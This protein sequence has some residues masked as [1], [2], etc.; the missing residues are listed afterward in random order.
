MAVQVQGSKFLETLAIEGR[1]ERLRID[2][3]MGVDVHPGDLEGSRV[4]GGLPELERVADHGVLGIAELDQVQET[5]G[6]KLRHT[7]GLDGATRAKN[8]IQSLSF[9]ME[10]FAERVERLAQRKAPPTDP[11]LMSFLRTFERISTSID[12]HVSPDTLGHVSQSE[13]HRLRRA[14][15]EL[16]RAFSAFEAKLV[17]HV[18]DTVLPR[19]ARAPNR[20]LLT[21][22]D[23]YEEAVYL[24]SVN[25]SMFTG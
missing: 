18:N 9:T 25:G 8:T 23:R 17:D 21:R 20:E 5:V 15:L 24:F 16:A 11:E 6:A 12:D 22:L 13:I 10:S 19:L 7:L 1:L 14:Y 4:K 3:V 2:V